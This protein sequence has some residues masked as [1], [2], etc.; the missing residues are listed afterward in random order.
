MMA[1][2]IEFERETVWKILTEDLGMRQV[3]AKMVP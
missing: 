3:S 1:E 2:E